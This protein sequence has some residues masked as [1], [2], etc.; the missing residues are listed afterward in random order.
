VKIFALAE[1]NLDLVKKTVPCS[2][3][4]MM[5]E[6]LAERLFHHLEVRCF[7]PGRSIFPLKIHSRNGGDDWYINPP[8]EM[9]STH[10]YIISHPYGLA[11]GSSHHPYVDGIRPAFPFILILTIFGTLRV[12]LM[13]ML[14]ALSTQYMRHT[15]IFILNVVSVSIGIISS[16][17]GTHIAVRLCCVGEGCH[18]DF[19]DT[20]HN[21]AI[22]KLQPHGR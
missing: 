14:L 11:S 1:E 12:P 8:V 18:W 3:G 13:F 4:E 15:P 19:A 7:Y 6:A 16:A 9:P 22:Y 10:V 21:V 20:G 5:E 2:G 17:L